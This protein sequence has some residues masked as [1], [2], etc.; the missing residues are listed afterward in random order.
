MRRS[1]LSLACI[2][3]FALPTLAQQTIIPFKSAWKYLDNGTN[4]GTAW[5][6]P[7]FNDASWQSGNGKLG[8]GITDAATVVSFGPS[9]SKKY[10]TTY[11][12]K[13]IT[14]QDASVYSSI[15]GKLNRD[16]GAIVYINGVEVLR[17]N[18]PSGT[19][20]HTT[21]AS[22]GSGGDDGLT[23]LTF[24]I[25]PSVLV[26]GANVI[27]VEIHQANQTSSDIAFDLELTGVVTST[28]PADTTPPTVT[29]ILRQQPLV[30]ITAASSLTFRVTF[31]EGVTGVDANDFILTRLSGSTTTG[32]LVV[33]TV[34][35]GGSTYDVTVAGVSGSG[36]IRL[37]LKSSGT[38][39]TDAAGNPISGGYTGGQTYT[40]EQEPVDQTP[41]AV[42]SIN[43]FSPT[44]QT[45]S[46]SQLI[47]QVA[48]SEGVTGVDPTDFTLTV[49][50]GSATGELAANAVAAA[51][52]GG[53]AYNVTLTAVSGEGTLRLDL[54]GSGTGITDAAGNTISGG[55]TDGQTYTIEQ[56]PADQTP[57]TLTAV[58]LASSNPN[59]ALAKPG[60]VV[61]LSFTASEAIAAP[62]VTVASHAVTATA[63]G[64]N[65]FTASYTLTAADAAGAVPFTIDFADLAGNT[66]TRVTA[67]T[68]ASSVTFDKIAPS[69]TAIARQQPIE[70][71]TSASSLTF[72]VAFSEAVTGLDAADFTLTQVSGSFTTGAVSVAGSGSSYDVTVAGVTGSGVIRLDLKSSGTGIAD[73]AG[74]PI[75]VG[76]TGGQT[77]TVQSTQQPPGGTVTFVAFKSAWK[78]LD[79]GSNQGTAWR[80]VSFNDA[81][82]ASGNGKFGY[83]I[84][85][86]ATVVSF[87]S[88]SSKK[89]L[90][91]YFRKSIT[92]QN[93]SSLT[94]C[95]GKVNRDD[96]VV[97]YINGV[98][99]L[100]N[101]MPTGTIT[102]TTKASSGSGGDD[103]FTPI[104]FTF[105]P[106]VLVNGTNVIAVEIHQANQTSSDI[107]FDLELTGEGTTTPV[108]HTP[109]TLIAV[110]LAS[111]NPNP[112]LAKPGDVVTLSFTASEAIAAPTVTVASHAVTATAAGTNAFTASY[113]LTAA[114]AA[115]AVPFTIDFA[116]VAG[117]T[118][119]RVTATTNA[120]AVVFDKIAP[121][122][123]AIAR[124]QPIEQTTSA[125]SL[126]FRVA[127]SEAVT[128]LDAADFTLTQASGSFTTGAV[129]VTGSSSSY[130]ITVAGV[131]GSGVIRLDLK[132]SGTGIADAAGNPI[133][134]GYT[135]G[136]T[137]T[138]EQEPVDQTP[139][140]VVSINR[141]SPTSQTTSSSQ[142]V[143]QVAFSEGVTGVDPTDFTLTV[144]SGSATGELAAN[145]VEEVGAGGAAYNVTLTAVGGEGTLR[146]DLKGSGTGITDAAGNTISGG[147]TG[148]QTYTIEQEPADQTPPTL[149]A[150]TLASSNPNPALAKPGDVVTLSFT[151]S[152]AIVAPTVT[153]ASHAVI[154]T[155]AGTNAF[156]ASYTLTAA[157]AAGAVPFTIDFADLAGNA[158]NRVT[159][160]TNDST[161]VFDN[162]LPVVTA[163]VRQLPTAENTS[164]SS[165]T[166]RV[167][168]SENVANVDA[169]D[170]TATILSGSFTTGAIS[171]T[172]LNSAVYDVTVAGV[173]GNGTLRLDLKSSGT[174][175]TDLAGNTISGG[176]TGGHTYSIS[177]LLPGNG[178]TTIINLAPITIST[179]TGEKPQS[180][181]WTHAG[182][183]WAVL[184][185][186]SGTYLW[187]LD[188]TNWTSILRLSTRTS[189]KADCKEVGNIA[190]ILLYQGSNSQM[191]SIEYVPALNTYQLW[192]RRT[193]TV[194]LTFES[195]VETATIDIDGTGRM[196]LAAAGVSDIK[197]R[198]SDSPYHVW[199]APITIATGVDDDDICAVIA[200]PG[201]IGVLWSN[202]TTRRFGFKTHADGAAPATWSNDEVPGDGSALNIG[203]G[204]ADD[205]MNL[206][207]SSDGTLYCAVKTSYNRSG[208][209]ELGLLVRR[210]SGIWDNFYEIS[211]AG[212]RPVVILNENTGMIRVAYTISDSG[213][214]ILYKESSA[215]TISFSAAMPLITGGVYNNSTTTKQTVRSEAVILASGN[216]QAVGVLVRDGLAPSAPVVPMLI[217]PVSESAN[218]A[219]SPDLSWTTSQHAGAYQ[220]QVSIN[221]TF[222]TTVFDQADIATSTVR[223]TGLAPHTTYYWRVRA[224]NQV[225]TSN[226]SSTSSFTTT[227]PTGHLV[228]HW[229]AEED[230]ALLFDNSNYG[231]NAIIHGNAQR[232]AGLLGQALSFNGT[233]QYASVASNSSLDI[234]EAITL[235]AW[236]KPEKAITQYVL[237]KAIS[238]ITDG[239]ELSLASNGQVFFRINQVSSGDDFRVSSTALHPTDGNTWMHVAATYDGSVA[240]IYIDGVE[241]NVM[242]FGTAL[243]TNSLN[244]AIGAESNGTRPLKGA[245]D[246]VRIYNIALSAADISA[247]AIVPTSGAFTAGRA[248]QQ[249]K[250]VP[251]TANELLAY[252]NPFKSVTTLHFALPTDSDYVVN[253]YDSKGAQLKTLQEGQATAG[254][255]QVVEVDGTNL[256]DGL[257]IVRLQSS[258][259]TKSVKLLLT[260]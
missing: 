219:V 91:T 115:G 197:V 193:S 92:V 139:P 252:P 88:N 96:G 202:Q 45:T 162:A 167:T 217:S 124:Q 153:I 95:T 184:P 200:M 4:Q 100:R 150:V 86:A 186:S 237:K 163:M 224:A 211:G 65:A 229:Q 121:T 195:G 14:I 82:W 201:K 51:G 81:S 44:S 260:K 116:D 185:N 213:G 198:W 255:E 131:T 75:S 143:Y 108:D 3:L 87:G 101:N 106:S 55:Y 165:L 34:G 28:P 48:F 247:L 23:P 164:A 238:G 214:D 16:D 11:F 129:S 177:Q 128:G 176:Y 196:W 166:F 93:A 145:A 102:Y 243:A 42:V 118:G 251:A 105:N 159:S 134:G 141:F 142:L 203:S 245:I 148:G 137:Y 235:A 94:S 41:P 135:G 30:Q 21:K 259:G 80:A 257:Y 40:I 127:F 123:T 85:D 78:Y 59:P 35:T 208:Y 222:A 221:S 223:A 77:Y 199:S 218:V 56:E 175:I 113:T 110:A 158:G 26:N 71:T 136:Q 13:S 234:T 109:P 151:A 209:P 12:R 220:A 19:I 15:S 36:V 8:Y 160:T 171:V 140:A 249:L 72:R 156:T 20:T 133:S 90:T 182:Q 103:G 191:V 157:D 194:G 154:A 66:G 24:S 54:K 31:S 79:N 29:T 188:G 248:T 70:Q 239:Y 60:D 236:I 190:H 132:S 144:L 138:I 172:D 53:A 225:G 216:T 73:A 69:I 246:D 49:L 74:N 212:T 22:G 180:K 149:T 226:W 147:Y 242:S 84:P 10:I 233:D 62:T 18:L 7:S 68:N 181:V 210:P 107:A 37:D 258:T 39:I 47:Y 173:T 117:N 146:L 114:D 215:G 155:A 256:P 6:A 27:A 230:G 9:S 57:P 5:R 204:M 174:G 126:T 170:F 46:S 168:F 122:V 89:H 178:F 240:K 205:H 58:T 25:S 250:A 76:Y 125:S 111:N 206:A 83:G 231:N 61:T 227:I 104:N 63:A 228:G 97:I 169:N 253:L 119:T 179:N 187:R 112:A 2:I 120:S 130:D 50:S 64:T 232:V 32:S 17:D 98:E 254:Q 189:T 1:I 99:V 38:G 183:H 43:R 152:E 207:I 244:L 241:D 161:I 33:A 52:T 67:T 192:S